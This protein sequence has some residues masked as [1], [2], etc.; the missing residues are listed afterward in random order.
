MAGLDA[1]Q[2]ENDLETYG[3]SPS[4]SFVAAAKRY[5][6]LL[7]RWNRTV[8]LTRVTDPDQLVR[9]HFGESIFAL[10]AVPIENGRLADVGSGA[11]FPGLALAMARPSL[12]VTLVESNAKKFTFLNEVVRELKLKNVRVLRCRME[13]VA[14]EERFRFMTARALG[15]HDLLLKLS[16]LYLDSSGKLVLWLGGRDVAALG[17]EGGW[18]WSPEIR[19]PGSRQRFLLFGSPQR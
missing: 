17:S 19:I 2:I 5:I 9:F 7:L 12:Q 11:G 3:F 14:I 13:E 4:P 15:Q 8:S 6:D 10:A 18:N 16:K 1:L